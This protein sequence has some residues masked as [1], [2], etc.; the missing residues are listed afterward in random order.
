MW[1]SYYTKCVV[2]TNML[3]NR[4]IVRKKINTSGC[5]CPW[6]H[7]CFTCLLEVVEMYS[8]LHKGTPCTLIL[9]IQV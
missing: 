2:T 9:I 6:V 3:W 1:K 8:V 7:L 5:A 4:Y